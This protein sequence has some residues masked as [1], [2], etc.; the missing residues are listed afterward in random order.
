MLNERDLSHPLAGGVEVH[1]E[2]IASRLASRHGIETTVLCAAFPG[3]I[4]EEVR[5]GVR[6]VRFGDR[7]FSYYATM[8]RRARAEL[9]AGGYDLVVENLCKL[10]FFS[11]AY[12]RG[13]PKLALVHH[14]FGLSAFRQVSAP[15]ASY[16]VA[17]E[18]LLPVA[19]RGWP[20][21]V[22]S[23]STRDDLVKRGIPRDSIRVV[24]NGLDH[25]RY[26]P[27]ARAA[28]SDL[29]VFVGRLEH[30]K[31]VD[32]LLDA[33][34]RVLA[35]RPG[36]R[37]VIVGEGT[38]GAAMRERARGGPFRD[39]V[40]FTGFLPE[41]DKIAWLQRATVLV[42]PSRKEGWGLT[43]LEANA[44]GTPVVATDVPGLRDS[45][46]HGGTGLLAAPNAA[47]LAASLAAVLGDEALRDRLARGARAW[48]ERFTWERVSDA[49]AEVVRAAAARR[50]LPEVPDFLAAARAAGERAEEAAGAATSR[51]VVSG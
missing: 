41:S 49:F 35:A 28:E 31:G 40:A 29:V 44:C 37:L 32:L 38:A 33:W 20:F 25:V 13:V 17:T 16:V 26:R 12:L 14:L 42:Q 4:P 11:S 3:A 50:P 8:P 22:V 9:A 43:V 34:P 27:G 5:N 47:S 19:Y 46:R 45:V 23:P 36:A 15:I 1:L 2:E 30:Y 24:P 7:G 39:S 51:V 18:A 48:A 6:Y 21:V 10:L